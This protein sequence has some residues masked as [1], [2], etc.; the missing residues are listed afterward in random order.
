MVKYL[1]RASLI[2][3]LY[4]ALTLI[5]APISY[6]PIQVRISE[7]LT[8]LPVFDPAAIPG[9]FIGCMIAN[10]AGGFGPWDIF[11]GSFIT[12]IAAI[13]SYYIGKKISPILAPISP[14]ILNSLGVSAYL[15]FLIHT[16]YLFLVFTIFIGELISAGGLGLFL[17][18]LIKYKIKIKV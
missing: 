6:G 1:V 4:I 5:F 10:I 2:S 3:A 18:W 13:L 9:L 15:T 16:P 14:I 8:I 7:M 11:L 12:L 17:Y